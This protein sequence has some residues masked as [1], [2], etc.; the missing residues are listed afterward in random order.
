MSCIIYIVNYN[1]TIHVTCLLTLTTYK[2][3]ELQVSSTTQ[4]LS[5]KANCKTLFFLVMMACPY[6]TCLEIFTSKFNFKLLIKLHTS[7]LG[8]KRSIGRCCTHMSILHNTKMYLFTLPWV[9]NL[10]FIV[11]LTSSSYLFVMSYKGVGE[12]HYEQV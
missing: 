4:K 3:N 7:Q 11:I 12:T 6:N 1:F 10:L 8:Y 9:L 2:Y 5:C